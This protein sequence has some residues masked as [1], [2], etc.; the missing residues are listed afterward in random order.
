ML[1]RGSTITSCPYNH[2]YV[3]LKKNKKKWKLIGWSDRQDIICVR[4]RL[5]SC[6]AWFREIIC[7]EKLGKVNERAV[8]FVFRDK[9][10]PYEELFSVLGR[11]TLLE[12]RLQKFLCTV[13][14]LVNHDTNPESMSELISPRE[15]T[16]ALRGNDILTM[17]KV[18]TTR[19]GLKS[20]CY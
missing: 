12:Q 9:R 8:R 17:P 7:T 13:Y 3:Q 10:T 4:V 20:W 19:F 14:K 1:Y 6:I 18:N 2:N 16:C 11:R 5:S 15:T